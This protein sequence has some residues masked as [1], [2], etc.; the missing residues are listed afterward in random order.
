MRHY[1]EIVR[2]DKSFGDYNEISDITWQLVEP[3][4][5]D[6]IEVDQDNEF[7]LDGEMIIINEAYRIRYTDALKDNDAIRMDGEVYRIAGLV[8]EKKL[9][10][11]Y[12][13]F[14]VKY[15]V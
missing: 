8:N 7:L 14:L 12:R 11:Y 2:P 13:L 10:R 6:L 4:R 15:G 5:A 9:N 3:A 1:L